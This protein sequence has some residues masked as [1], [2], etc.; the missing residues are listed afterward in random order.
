MEI[1]EVLPNLYLS[2][3]ETMRFYM[4]YH[5]PHSAITENVSESSIPFKEDYVLPSLL[6]ELCLECIISVGCDLNSPQNRGLSSTNDGYDFPQ[7]YSFPQFEDNPSCYLLD[8]CHFQLNDI[9]F[10]YLVKKQKVVVHCV[11]GQSRSV[12][13]IISYMMKYHHYSLTEAFN[14]IKEVKSSISVN[15]GFLTQLSFYDLYCY[16]EYYSENYEEIHCDKIN[17]GKESVPQFRAVDGCSWKVRT[18]EN[19]KLP[20]PKD[21]VFN[22]FGQLRLVFR[23]LQASYNEYC[24]SISAFSSHPV[25]DGDVACNSCRTTLIFSDHILNINHHFFKDSEKIVDDC[26]DSFWRSYSLPFSSAQYSFF[27]QFSETTDSCSSSSAQKKKKRKLCHVKDLFSLMDLILKRY[28]VLDYL[29]DTLKSSASKNGDAVVCI[30][31]N[32]VIG[33][34]FLKCYPLIGK[35]CF[36]NLYILLRENCRIIKINK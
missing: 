24:L 13:A 1:V 26:L 28:Y 36:V 6:Q 19:D 35:Y 10:S 31:C 21:Q 17:Y 5:F 23:L 30:K 7:F 11:Y 18:E 9:I 34:Y 3:L 32:S 8:L 12:T 20:L 25:S 14:R 4:K 27:D 16:Y 22:I 29:P 33:K 15:P 2:N